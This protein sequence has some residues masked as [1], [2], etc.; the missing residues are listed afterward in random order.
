MFLSAYDYTIQYKC[1]KSH[2]NAEFLS[3]LPV[4]GNVELQDPSTAFQVSF[5]EELLCTNI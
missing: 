5:I 3:R 1:G 4:Q 2:T